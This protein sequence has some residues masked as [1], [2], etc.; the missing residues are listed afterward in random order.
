MIKTIEGGVTAAKGFRAC[1]VHA[2]VKTNNPDKKDLA[3]IVSDCEAAAAAVFFF[4]VL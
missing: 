4:N 3:L 1:G 2:G